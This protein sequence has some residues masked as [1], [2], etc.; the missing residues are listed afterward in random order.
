MCNSVEALLNKETPVDDSIFVLVLEAIKARKK[1]NLSQVELAVKAKV[2][3]TDVIYLEQLCFERVSLG[4]FIK[5]IE[6]LGF[7]VE[8]VKKEGC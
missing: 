6:A 4:T 2:E 3:I 5:I 1:Q 7:N 8:I